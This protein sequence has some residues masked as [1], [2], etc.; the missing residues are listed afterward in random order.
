[1]WL[2]KIKGFTVTFTLTFTCNYSL[3]WPLLYLP[4]LA[5]PTPPFKHPL[6]FHDI[7]IPP[8][9]PVPIFSP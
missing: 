5:G 3:I 6:C 7:Y 1:M 2:Y 8:P 9:S 4:H